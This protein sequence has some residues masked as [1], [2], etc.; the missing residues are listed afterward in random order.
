MSDLRKVLTLVMAVAM[1]TVNADPGEPGAWIEGES[2]ALFKAL[3]SPAETDALTA[4]LETTVDFEAISRGVMG[5]HRDALSDAQQTE[6]RHVFQSSLTSL[7]RDGLGSL[8][9]YELDV[10]KARVPRPGRAQ[11]PVTVTSS[12]GVYEIQFSLAASDDQW[13]VRNM[14]VNGVNLGLTYRNQ[15]A[16]LMRTHDGDVA[17]VIAGWTESVADSSEIKAGS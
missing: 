13:R 15:F 8:G 9:D 17:A 11:V 14:I 10:A 7:L 4:R 2:T 3:N 16:E 12:D 1:L 5:K 6:F